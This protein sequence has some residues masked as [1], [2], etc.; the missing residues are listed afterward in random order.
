MRQDRP[1]K[2]LLDQLRD[3]IRI[4][5]YSLRTEEAYVGWVRRFI[6]FHNK[7]HPLEMGSGEINQFIA[8]LAVER[9]MSA[10]SQNQAMSAILFLYRHVLHVKLDGVRIETVNP[11]KPKRVP[12]VLSKAEAK[13]VIRKMDGVCRIMAQIMYGCGLRLMRV[14]TE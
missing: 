2:K 1:P 5:H 8:Y 11:R 13:S 9:H 14:P 7:R 3:H 10:S 4:R 12:S 6:L